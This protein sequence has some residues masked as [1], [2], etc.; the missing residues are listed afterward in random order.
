MF[1]PRI[2]KIIKENR[3]NEDLMPLMIKIG[4]IQCLIIGALVVGFISF[5]SSFIVDIWNKPG[6]SES[7]LC[8]VLIILPSF[9]Y[10]PMQIANTTLV[11]ENKVKLQ[12]YVFIITGLANVTIS[13]F[14]SKYF[15]AIGA[16]LSIFIAYMIRTLLFVIIYQKQIKL[17]MK[18]FFKQTYLKIAP[19]LLVCMACGLLMENFNPIV[20]KY[21]RFGVNGTVFVVVFVL[22][23][24]VMFMN[25]YEKNLF[26][27][28][29]GKIFKKIL[30]RS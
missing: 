3:K 22:L 8:A 15:G 7:Y 10:Q 20:N 6:F 11:V 13:V 23:A 14:L 9:F 17:D 30:R 2:S 1:L 16:S 25:N 19:L 4:R 5:G 21:L 24:R 27:G 26:F 29:T 12:A 28:T 18:E